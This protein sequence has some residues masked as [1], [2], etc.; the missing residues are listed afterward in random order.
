[1][2]RRF[3]T[4]CLCMA[5]AAAIY[6]CKEPVQVQL[7]IRSNLPCTAAM[8][9]AGEAT[10]IRDIAIFAGPSEAAVRAR[11]AARE[12]PSALIAQCTQTGTPQNDFLGDI[13]LVRSNSST[14]F[15]A[16]VAGLARTTNGTRTEKPAS[17]CAFASGETFAPN[18]PECLIAVRQFQ[19]PASNANSQLTVSLDASCLE[20]AST[21]KTGE[22]CINGACR[23]SQVNPGPNPVPTTPT[24]DAGIDTGTQAA[25]PFRCESGSSEWTSSLICKEPGQ[26]CIEPLSGSIGCNSGTK[27]VEC[28]KPCCATAPAPNTQPFEGPDAKCCIFDVLVNGQPVRLP[29]G[30]VSS[31]CAPQQSHA[32]FGAIECDACKGIKTTFDPKLGW[33]VC[34]N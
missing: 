27:S 21:C 17:D 30:A 5:P 22:T 12:L 6:A 13:A 32:C 31:M 8:T 7:G 1:M 4:A 16:V 10:S 11:I 14:V 3:L 33:G 15:V 20:I 18:S 9:S 28:L 34:A 24:P 2:R 19:Y 25:S 23:S 26:Q 29:L